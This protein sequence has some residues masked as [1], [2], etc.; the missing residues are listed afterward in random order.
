MSNI[1]ETISSPAD[2]KKLT[3]PELSLAGGGD[4]G[5]ADC[6]SFEDG[7]TYRAESGRR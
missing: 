2:V 3:I 7:R 6:R 4:T 5:A 1:L